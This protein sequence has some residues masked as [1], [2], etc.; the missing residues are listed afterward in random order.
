[1]SLNH[2]R[3][4]F[5]FLVSCR[6]KFW[7]SSSH[8]FAMVLFGLGTSF[9]HGALLWLRRS[10]GLNTGIGS[11]RNLMVK[12]PLWS[13]GLCN[14]SRLLDL[15]QGRMDLRSYSEFYAFDFGDFSECSSGYFDFWTQPSSQTWACTRHGYNNTLRPQLKSWPHWFSGTSKP[16]ILNLN[17]YTLQIHWEPQ[18]YFHQYSFKLECCFRSWPAFLHTFAIHL[19]RSSTCGLLS[20]HTLLLLGLVLI[21]VWIGHVLMVSRIWRHLTIRYYCNLKCLGTLARHHSF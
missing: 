2:H 17:S 6:Y 14:Q 11:V 18:H 9:C 4:Q 7:L 16:I 8:Q 3:R 12:P 19:I 10:T 20:Y 1:M 15:D 21:V 5:R 13:L